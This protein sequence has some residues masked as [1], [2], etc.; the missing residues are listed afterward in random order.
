MPNKRY[1]PALLF[2]ILF[3]GISFSSYAE[4]GGWILM[5]FFISL[6]VAFRGNPKLKGFS[7]TTMIFGVVAAG[8]Y[9]PQYFVHIGSFKLSALI[10]PLLQVIHK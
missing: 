1:L 10:I 7:F 3:I 9:Y 5:L 2:L 6:A 8:M 4:K